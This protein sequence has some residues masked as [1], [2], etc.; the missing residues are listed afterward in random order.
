MDDFLDKKVKRF[1]PIT[2]RAVS[3]FT[4]YVANTPKVTNK[5]LFRK[6]IE[7]G[8]NPTDLIDASLGHIRYEKSSASLKSNLEDILNNVYEKDPTPGKRYVIDPSEAISE[9]AKDVAKNLGKDLG[10]AKSLNF[11]R[12]RSLPDYAAVSN[13]HS[14]LEKLKAISDAGHELQHQVDFL[15]RPDMKMETEFPFRQGHHFGNVYETSELIRE[16][17]DLPRNQKELDEIVKQSKKA[18]LKPS[19]FGRLFSLLGKVGPIGAGVSALAALKSGDVG[20]AALNAASAVDPTGISDATLEVKNR[21]KMS[22]EEQEEAAK[23]DRY[24]AM[25]MDIANEQRML[26]DLDKYDDKGNKFK[27][28]REKVR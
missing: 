4:D 17:K 22:T 24:S 19:T 2:P 15:I 7:M 12:S 11:G 18:G 6:A 5:D 28:I 21:L 25:P 27:K 9:R 23:E 20:A 10:V 14:D 13:R 16:A 26:D 3:Q 1:S 8:Y